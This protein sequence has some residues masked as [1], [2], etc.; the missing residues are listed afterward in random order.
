MSV[1][2]YDKAL[3]SKLK[4][5]IKDDSLTLTSPNE[6]TRLF[7]YVADTTNDKPIQLPLVAIRKSPTITLEQ[8]NKKPLSFDGQRYNQ[9]EGEKS[10]QLNAIPMSIS[11]QIDIYTRYEEEAE[12]YVRNFVFN[13]VNFPKLTIEIPYNSSKKQ[14]NANIKVVPDIVNNSDIPERLIP[15]QFTRYTIS[16]Y[17]DDAYL[18]NYRAKEKWTIESNTYVEPILANAEN[19]IEGE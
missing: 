19:R 10:N 8:V 12:D 6:T 14:H 16:I 3:V 1:S 5:W 2:L 11:Y 7:E 4:G 17:I 15:G 9:E 18:W 13:L